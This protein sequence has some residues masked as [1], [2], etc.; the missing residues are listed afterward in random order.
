MPHIPGHHDPTDPLTWTAGQ[1]IIMVTYDGKAPWGDAMPYVSISREPIFYGGKWGQVANITLNGRISQFSYDVGKT[2][3]FYDGSGASWTLDYPLGLRNLEKIRD[4]IIEVLSRS[5]K[6]FEF[7]DSTNH[8]MT[9]PN[10][11]VENIDFPTSGYWAQ[12]DFSITLKC[13]EQDYFMAQGVMDAVDEFQTTEN[14]NGTLNVS[15]RISARG[16]NYTDHNGDEQHGLNNAITWVDSR[17]G[18]QYKSEEGIYKAWW[19]GTSKTEVAPA[20]PSLPAQGTVDDGVATNKIHLILLSQDET[21]NRLEGT[22]EISETFIGYLGEKE[23]TATRPYGRRFS[24]NINESLT[25]S[26][27]VVTISG[28]YTG[29][30]DTSLKELRDGFVN[31]N[32]TGDPTL[33]AE[34]EKMLYQKAKELSGFDG[35]L[36]ADC[37][38]EDPPGTPVPGAGTYKPMLYDLPMGFSIEE[39]E[40]DKSIKIKATFD[41][42]PLFKEY[43]EGTGAWVESRYFFDHK[44]SVKMNEVTN[45]TTVSIDGQLLV[46]GLF[47]EKQFYV[48]EFLQN[49]DVMAFLWEKADKEH[50]KIGK[51]CWLCQGGK[52]P[53]GHPK[54]GEDVE[55]DDCGASLGYTG[56]YWIRADIGDTETEADDICKA[57]PYGGT[58]VAGR[59]S[60]RCHELNPSATSL[61]M[62]KNQVK[63][64]LSLAASFSDE[65]TLP[66]LPDYDG[67]HCW[68]CEDDAHI[69]YVLAMDAAEALINCRSQW[70]QPDYHVDSAVACT[71]ID[72]DCC[73]DLNNYFYGKSSWSVNVTSPIDYA[74]ANASAQAKYNGH[75]AIQKLGIKTRE[76]TKVKVSLD[77]REDNPYLPAD[78]FE[79][80]LRAQSKN[81]VKNLHEMFDQDYPG[82]TGGPAPSPVYDISENV[83]HKITKGDSVSHSLE[84]SYQPDEANAICIEI[85]PIGDQKDCYVCVDVYGGVADSANLGNKVYAYNDVDAQL[86]CDEISIDLGFDAIITGSDPAIHTNTA[87]DCGGCY[88]CWS[89]ELEILEYVYSNN[90][91]NAQAACPSG[92][93]AAECD[94]EMETFCFQCVEDDGTP[95]GRTVL[96]PPAGGFETFNIVAADGVCAA[97]VSGWPCGNCS[98]E[99]CPDP[100]QSCWTCYFYGDEFGYVFAGD[101]NEA[102]DECSGISHGSIPPNDPDLFVDNYCQFNEIESGP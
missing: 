7:V 66:I 30:K 56:P 14:E 80:T 67:E 21:I 53:T 3:K 15:H 68:S 98:V 82:P 27:N 64:T 84:R 88:A 49:R 86:L 62:T 38:E 61:S 39:S 101:E 20:D 35:S 25:S 71:D 42:N 37:G 45:V 50:G 19:G 99:H 31:D 92:T 59:D 10:A 47:Q 34:P 28:E 41:T 33:P 60:E 24:V 12:F 69:G 65:D 79:R 73:S 29:G 44:I 77:F 63:G 89:A 102:Y 81:T 13:Y 58:I 85:D 72:G 2:N 91:A 43:D 6:V 46:R 48:K 8:K 22:Y 5:L 95:E 17:K 87:E 96:Y 32:P 36:I 97:E 23:N 1:G 26:F 90:L 93:N 40:T 83:S 76:K 57:H 54:V 18:D 55:Q 100:V 51:N 74:K 16:V 9:F 94:L 52:Y 4:D 75:W 11:I 70:P 78:L